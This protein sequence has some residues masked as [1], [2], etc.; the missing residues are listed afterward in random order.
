LTEVGERPTTS[1]VSST[2]SPPKYR[3]TLAAG[4]D[5][6]PATLQKHIDDCDAAIKRLSI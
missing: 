5:A 4:E 3:R 2:V 6:R 1:A